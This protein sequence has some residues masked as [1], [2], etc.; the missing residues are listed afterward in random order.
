MIRTSC[1]ALCL[2]IPS[3]AVA[4][5]SRFYDL[6]GFG[7]FLDGNPE[8]TA[9]GEDGTIMLPTAVKERHDDPTATYGAAAALGN[10]VVV[11]RVDD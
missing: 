11:S 6:E 3:L 2:C 8:S 4:E 1:I 9:V 7:S 5:S 10:D